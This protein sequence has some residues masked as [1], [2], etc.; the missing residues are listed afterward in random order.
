MV[1]TLT[2]RMGRYYIKLVCDRKNPTNGGISLTDPL[3]ISSL[4]SG[5]QYVV[6]MA[7]HHIHI[8]LVTAH[9][10]WGPPNG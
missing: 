9:W 2:R 1:F 10:R 6:L 7:V 5:N 4:L 8:D 3:A